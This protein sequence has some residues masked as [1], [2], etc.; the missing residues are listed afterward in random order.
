MRATAGVGTGGD[1]RTPSAGDGFFGVP[2]LDGTSGAAV[3]DAADG[4]IRWVAKAAS[5]EG[6][7]TTAAKGGTLFCGSATTLRA[8]RAGGA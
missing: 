7:W 3:L 8:F 6:P 2:L 4:T 5:D 1:F